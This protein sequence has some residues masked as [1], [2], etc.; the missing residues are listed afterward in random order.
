[1]L[2]RPLRIAATGFCFAV[3]GLLGL[4]VLCVFFP[5]FRLFSFFRPGGSDS[6]YRMR[7][8]VHYGMRWFVRIM[9]LCGTISYEVRHAEKL[10]RQGLL[11]VANHPSLIDVVL[12]LSLLRQPNCVVKANLRT[13]LFTRGPVRSAGF[14]GNTDGPQLIDEC[15]ASVCAGDNLIIFPEGTRS[16]THDGILSP[17]KRGAANIALR[18][19][20]ALTPVVITVSEPMLG[21]CQRWYQAPVRL[22]HFVLTV[23]NDIPAASYSAIAEREGAANT[24]SGAPFGAHGR[25]ARTLTQDLGAL[26]TREIQR[27]TACAAL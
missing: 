16:L 3:F 27:Q 4:S 1:M 12:L 23:M 21:K 20:F 13:N 14:V 25:M 15:I 11:V 26:F 10:N 2:E 22:P 19:N 17:M 6:Q 24:G 9:V 18:G 7:A 5:L 8:L